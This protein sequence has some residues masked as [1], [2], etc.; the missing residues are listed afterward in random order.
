MWQLLQ[1]AT[2]TSA[3]LFQPVM[4]E[5]LLDF[6]ITVTMLCDTLCDFEHL[7][8]NRCLVRTVDILEILIEFCVI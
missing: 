3:W 2:S 5:E 7:G 6:L 8:S 1:L 4:S